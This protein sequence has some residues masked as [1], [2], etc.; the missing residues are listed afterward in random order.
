LEDP[1]DPPIERPDQPGPAVGR[2]DGAQDASAD[3][4]ASAGRGAAI[5]ARDP[6]GAWWL[7]DPRHA[8]PA[9]PLRRSSRGR[10]SGGG[11]FAKTFFEALAEVRV[12]RVVAR[13]SAPPAIRP[14]RES[15]PGTPRKPALRVKAD[16]T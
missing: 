11:R 9:R 15:R 10:R 14:I 5:P 3:R 1:S 16:R 7:T 13:R 6:A 4:P 12:T 8:R 2:P